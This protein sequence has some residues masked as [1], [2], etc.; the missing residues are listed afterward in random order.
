MM[1]TGTSQKN[2]WEINNSKI[3]YSIILQYCPAAIIN[4]ISVAKKRHGERV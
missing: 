4:D 1:M 3:R 2:T